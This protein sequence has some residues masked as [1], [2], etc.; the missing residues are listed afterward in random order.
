MTAH[1]HPIYVEIM[2]PKDEEDGLAERMVQRTPQTAKERD[3]PP[4]FAD[5]RSFEHSY[6]L[7]WKELY[8][9]E[10]AER[11]RL[12]ENLRAKRRQLESDMEI[13]YEDYQAEKIR[14]ELEQRKREL[15]RLEEAK[16]NRVRQIGERPP[17]FNSW[18]Q[19]PRQQFDEFQNPNMPLPYGH[20]PVVHPPTHPQGP[21]PNFDG[22]HGRPNPTFG[23]EPPRFFGGPNEDPDLRAHRPPGDSDQKFGPEIEKI[24]QTFRGNEDGVRQNLNK[25]LGFS[26]EGPQQ[27]QGPQ[28][29][30]PPHFS[31]PIIQPAPLFTMPPG[32]PQHQKPPEKRRR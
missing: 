30:G 24:L 17:E 7:R 25:S 31:T 20:P 26:G 19:P 32:R 4:H 10:R 9:F 29:G 5:E 28:H 22:P 6:G 12:E 18:S 14:E 27:F 1:S 21:P 23:R 3:V 15:D 11:E 2:E 8:S 16:R 13:A